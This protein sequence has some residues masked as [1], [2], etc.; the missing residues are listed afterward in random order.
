MVMTFAMAFRAGLA[1]AQ[2]AVAHK[3]P[4]K[5]HAEIKQDVIAHGLES[6]YVQDAVQQ[7][8]KLITWIGSP[9]EKHAYLAGDD[10]S[11]ADVSRSFLTWCVSIYFG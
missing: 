2:Q 9:L 7:H 10:F 6:K 8:R 11:L 1:Q 5:K 3:A 4:N